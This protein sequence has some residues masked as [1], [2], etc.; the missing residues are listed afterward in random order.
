MIIGKNAELIRA[1]KLSEQ[2]A[3]LLMDEIMTGSIKVGEKLPSETELC[4]R[5][6]VSRTSIREATGRLEYDGFLEIKRGSRAVVTHPAQRKAFRIEKF[7][8]I[9]A[10]EF[11]QIYQFRVIIE[12]AAVALMIK[13]PDKKWLKKLRICVDKMGEIYEENVKD[14]DHPASAEIALNLEFH[15]LIAE[16]SGNKFLRDFML[17]LNDKISNMLLQDF[18]KLMKLGALKKV[19]EEHVAI[20]QAIAAE[21]IISAKQCVFNHIYHA[22][23]RHDIEL[24]DIFD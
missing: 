20:Y 21:D 6:D 19:H 1:P 8:S 13:N 11:A 22:A 12:C 2:V 23:G 9:D 18:R 4:S 5:F 16:G 24:E 3:K 7:S 10:S 17:F 14:I 15:H